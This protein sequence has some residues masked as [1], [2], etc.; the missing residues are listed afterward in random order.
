MDVATAT[1][2]VPTVIA[3]IALVVNTV[4]AHRAMKTST[5]NAK[6]ALR[7]TFLRDFK[8]EF[9]GLAPARRRASEF[10]VSRLNEEGPVPVSSL[11]EVPPE[12][13]QVLDFF[14]K[15]AMYLKRGH[16]DLEMTYI[17][18][19]YWM[20]PYWTFFE[21]DVVAIRPDVPLLMYHEIPRQLK[22]L[23]RLA[24]GMDVTEEEIAKSKRWPEIKM[25]FELEI[26]ECAPKWHFDFASAAQG[27]V[28]PPPATAAAVPTVIH[29]QTSAVTARPRR[30]SRDE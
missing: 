28:V 6:V 4:T 14:D 24:P 3:L 15:L 7:A 12:V 20:I 1:L 2:V 13:W 29:G 23:E 18:F 21:G 16:V 22:K 27:A 10:A 11:R 5:E 25:F 8:A 26:E 30:L 19:V 9:E 17:A